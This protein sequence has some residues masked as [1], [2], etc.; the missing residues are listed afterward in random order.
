MQT[1]AAGKCPFCADN[2]LGEKIINN[3][4]LFETRS[5]RVLFDHKPMTKGHLIVIPKEHRTTRFDLTE[6]ECSDLY[7]VQKTISQIFQNVFGKIQNMQYEKNGLGIPHFQIHVMPVRSFLDLIWIQIKLF[8]R[9]FP[10][11]VWTL[12]QK[13]MDQQKTDFLKNINN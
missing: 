7:S 1:T 11:P 6:E 12:S 13:T 9:T 5:W 10:I 8:L 3:Q 2:P 4:V